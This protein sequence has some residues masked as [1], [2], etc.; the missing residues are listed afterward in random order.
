MRT[1]IDNWVPL[2]VTEINEIFSAI[3]IMW[4]IAGG[5]ALDLHI[6]KKSNFLFK[7]RNPTFI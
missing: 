1:D 5:W 7:T 3:P 6:G 2:T 4:C